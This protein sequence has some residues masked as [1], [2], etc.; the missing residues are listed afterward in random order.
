MW[1][2]IL[3]VL[4]QYL[5]HICASILVKLI[6]TAEDNECNLTVTENTQFISFLH[7]TKFPFVECYLHT[8]T[9]ATGFMTIKSRIC[10]LPI[11]NIIYANHVYI[12]I[13]IIDNTILDVRAE[14]LTAV[15]IEIISFSDVRIY[16]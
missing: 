8:E 5:V 10:Q 11:C 4:E 3:S 7:Y 13:Y 2:I 9:T 16:N 1:F 14:I 6:G 12:S 15:N